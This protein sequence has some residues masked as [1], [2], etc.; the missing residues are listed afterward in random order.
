M[1]E[2]EGPDLAMSLLQSGYVPYDENLARSVSA[3]DLAS[4]CPDPSTHEGVC[5]LVHASVFAKER[6]GRVR[7]A[8][9]LRAWYDD[10][11]SE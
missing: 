8:A 6:S 4:L 11:S 1:A 10:N 2:S 9:T 3:N 5:H 7:A